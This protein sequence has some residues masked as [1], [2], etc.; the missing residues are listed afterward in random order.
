MSRRYTK[1]FQTGSLQREKRKRGPDVW[2]FRFRDEQTNR[3]EQVGTVEQ[4]PNKT[5]A[6]KA[7]ELLRSNLNRGTRVPHT[8]TELVNHYTD[9]ELPNKTPYTREVYEGYLKTWIVPKWGTLMLSDVKSVAVESWLGTLPLANGT[10]A[11]LRNL[12]HA[13][14][15]HGMRWEFVNTNPICQT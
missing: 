12:M 11:K 4:F 9:H 13:V 8:V 10:K 7:C 5:A 14:Y 2:I 15:T 3:K 6:L 1:R